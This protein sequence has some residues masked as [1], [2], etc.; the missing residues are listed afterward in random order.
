MAGAY[1]C[2]N[3]LISVR[4]SNQNRIFRDFGMKESVAVPAAH[5]TFICVEFIANLLPGVVVYIAIPQNHAF[6]CISDPVDDAAYLL[7]EV[8]QRIYLIIDLLFQSHDLFDAPHKRGFGTPA[9]LNL[10]SEHG[11]GDGRCHLAQP[12][13]R[14]FDF[15]VFRQLKN[16]GKQR[17]GNV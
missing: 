15:V 2:S 1:L 17:G 4:L 6:I 7:L 8:Y 16:A 14:R 5:G 11:S 13:Q 10:F 9:G 12:C 3:V